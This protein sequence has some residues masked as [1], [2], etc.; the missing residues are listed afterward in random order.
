MFYT[1]NRV[2]F[3]K[4]FRFP[5]KNRHFPSIINLPAV[6][7]KLDPQNINIQAGLTAHKGAKNTK[8]TEIIQNSTGKM[9]IILYGIFLCQGYGTNDYCFFSQY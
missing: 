2:I 3:I 6:N 9:D 1:A 5:E 8:I 7:P 4:I